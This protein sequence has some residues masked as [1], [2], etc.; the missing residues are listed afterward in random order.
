MYK[1]LLSLSIICL[2]TGSSFAQ[3]HLGIKGGA[4]LNKLTGQSFKDQFSWGYHIGGFAEIGL[5]RKFALQPEV[6]L[7]QVNLDTSSKFSSIYQF[8]HVSSVQLK[9]LS[10]PLLLDYKVNSFIALQAGPQFG[11]LI[12]QTK[13]LVQNGGDAFKKG[14][15]SML[16]GIQLHLL[17][18]RIYGRYAVGLN[19]IANISDKDKWKSQSVQLGIGIAL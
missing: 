19:D 7:N 12:D 1:K 3:F 18:F 6:L 16:A 14:D 8:N 4:N 10:I 17:K 9:Y 11:I 15:F 13:N 2:I 5:G